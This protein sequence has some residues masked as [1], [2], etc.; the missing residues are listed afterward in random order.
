[1]RA[2]RRLARVPTKSNHLFTLVKAARAGLNQKMRALT[3][4]MVKS[5]SVQTEVL[6]LTVCAG[7]E[8]AGELA[9]V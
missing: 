5:S 3:S 6:Y 2:N 8:E 9:A 1:M 7:L 4:A